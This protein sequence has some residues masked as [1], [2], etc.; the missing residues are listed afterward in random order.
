MVELHH[1]SCEHASAATSDAAELAANVHALKAQMISAARRSHALQSEMQELERLIA[2]HI[3]HR[4]EVEDRRRAP[5][6]SKLGT[7]VVR[8]GVDDRSRYELLVYLVR[9]KPWWLARLVLAVGHEVRPQL[10]HLILNVLYADMH[11]DEDD[12]LLLA[13]MG[14]AL[15]QETA[16]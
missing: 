3:R 9:V 13:L 14:D 16:R 15:E 5:P 1:L 12:A 4:M 8:L 11:D 2:L 10:I 7:E 6:A